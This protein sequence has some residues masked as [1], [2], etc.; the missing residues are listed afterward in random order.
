[1]PAMLRLA[2]LLLGTLAAAPAA[3]GAGPDRAQYRSEDALRRYAQGRLLE[4]QGARGE[5][6]EE[7]Y[8][9][10]FLDPQAL[11]IP[12]RVS[13]VA[14][15]MGDPGRSLEFAERALAADPADPRA[16]W[17]KGAALLNLGRDPE[18]LAPLE[19]AARADSERVEYVRTLARA[20]ERLG[21]LDLLAHCYRRVTW[22]EEDDGEAW[23]Q[24]AAAEAW[25]GR[26][27][28]A[29]SA[30]ARAV[31]LNPLR[32]GLFFLR[33][34]IQE[35]LGQDAEAR[36]SYGQHLQIHPDDT[37][38]RRRLAALL[39]R[40]KRYQDALREARLLSRARPGDLDLRHLEADLN[41]TLGKDAE[42][43]RLLE[44]T[45]HDFPGSPEAVA[46]RVGVLARHG[47]GARAVQEAEGWLAR[48]PGDLRARLLAARAR[49]MNRQ[50]DAALDHLRQ[51]VAMAPDS[52]LPRVL[53]ARGYEGADRLAEAEQVWAAALERHPMLSALAFD[54][55]LCREKLGDLAGAEAAVR[56]VLEREPDNA[57]ALNFLGYLF[58]DHNRNLEEAVELIQR[59]LEQDP[60][61]G[62]YL[63]SL[64]WAYYRLGRLEEARRYLERALVLSGG[65]PVIHEHLGDV[66]KDLRLED[67]ARDQYRLSLSLDTGNQRVRTKLSSLR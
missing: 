49:E 39:V 67:L 25:R 23:F 40:E 55:A 58:A 57:T 60:E 9:A 54:L 19:R 61:N 10:L 62:A 45:R 12:R 37:G 52:V 5:A 30:I 38:T 42:G 29:D 43:M 13:E 64:G 51:A 35:S 50:P 17:L 32:P 63:D 27:R 18:A 20:A 21:R 3:A 56:D 16:S 33:G 48:R 26:F 28:S 41:F 15:A 4:E 59:A 14:A 24:L 46:M 6:L 44:R 53:L 22:L 7:Y 66:Y 11:E 47:R 34:W 8:R 1:M 31:E 36:L 2:C 65:D